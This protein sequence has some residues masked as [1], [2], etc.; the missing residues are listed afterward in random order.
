MQDKD[1]KTTINEC[2]QEFVF[3]KTTKLEYTVIL[4]YNSLTA[5][6]VRYL[7]EAQPLVLS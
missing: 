6:N 2:Q 1:D 4:K 3:I 5:T 7:V